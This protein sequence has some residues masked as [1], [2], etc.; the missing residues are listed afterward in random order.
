MNELTKLFIELLES[1]TSLQEPGRE[2]VWFTENRENQTWTEEVESKVA[3]EK[4]LDLWDKANEV[5]GSDDEAHPFYDRDG[6]ETEDRLRDEGAAQGVDVL[7]YY[8]TFRSINKSKIEQDWGIHFNLGNFFAFVRRV[9]VSAGADP[10]IAL[11]ACYHFVL[12]HEINHYEVDLGIFFLE[13]HSGQRQYF[14]RP[15]PNELEEAL[16][17][18]RGVSHPNVKQFKRFILHRYEHSSLPGYRDLGSYLTLKKQNDA[19]N[20]ILFDCVMPATPAVPF[21]HEFM[22]PGEP[23]SSKRVPI[24]LHI[25]N[26]VPKAKSESSFTFQYVISS[27]TY[28]DSAK[29]DLDKLSKKNGL[30][31]KKIKDA[32]RKIIANPGANGNRLRKFQGAKD[33]IEARVDRGYRMLLRDKG[34]GAYELL[35]LGNDLYDH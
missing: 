35:H 32:E 21:G 10:K 20:K 14:N 30:L 6:V 16:G 31:H 23:F 33:L 9:A 8:R 28:S 25:G 12:H 34:D 11:P 17:S 4:I 22:K 13:S 7:A 19:Y 29:R 15:Y 5:I 18:G 1:H 27:I 3:L 26:H 24:F 2:P